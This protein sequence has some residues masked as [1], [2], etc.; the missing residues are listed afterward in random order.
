MGLYQTFTPNY[1]INV[2]VITWMPITRGSRYLNTPVV[3]ITR[4]VR[5]TLVEDEDGDD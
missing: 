4:M 1:D 3:G 2:E 5:L